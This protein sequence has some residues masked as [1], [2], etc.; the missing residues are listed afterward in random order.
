MHNSFEPLSNGAHHTQR[1]IEQVEPQGL[2]FKAFYGYSGSIR[3]MFTVA[4]L[5][6]FVRVK[7]DHLSKTHPQYLKHKNYTSNFL[8]KNTI[9]L[10]LAETSQRS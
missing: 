7:D 6:S 1:S 2:Y 3:Y 9:C 5:V 8:G 10:H 4:V